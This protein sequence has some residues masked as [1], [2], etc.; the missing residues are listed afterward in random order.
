MTT[1]NCRDDHEKAGDD[2]KT[3]GG[4]IFKACRDESNERVQTSHTSGGNRAVQAAASAPE[5]P[6][7]SFKVADPARQAGPV[8]GRALTDLCSSVCRIF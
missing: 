1:R 6:A 2:E 8:L 5:A 4:V 7:T 3:A